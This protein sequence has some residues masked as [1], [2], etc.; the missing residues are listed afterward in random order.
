MSYLDDSLLRA[1]FWG[2]ILISMA[3]AWMGTVL[4]LQRRT[5]VGELVSHAS[6]P[7][8]VLMILITSGVAPEWAIWLGGVATSWFV[9]RALHAMER[10]NTK[11]DAA[12]TFL[13]ASS[14]GVGIL[15]VSYLQGTLPR[16]TLL[17][18]SF[19]YGQAATLTDSAV[20]LY[21]VLA[22]LIGLFWLAAF[23]LLRTHL[24]DRAFAQSR[25]V[26]VARLDQILLLLTLC[27]IALGIRSVGVILMTGL[28]IAPPIAAR[29]WTNRLGMLWVIAGAI[30]ALSGMVGLVISVEGALAWK[31]Y[32][33]LSRFTLPT[34]PVIVLVGA[35]CALFSLLFAP[36]RGWIARSLR[37]RSF[38]RQ[39]QEEHLLKALWKKEEV[40]S[41][42]ALQRLVRQGWVS[43][44]GR[45][46]EDGERRAASIVRLH[47]LWEVYL[48]EL[49]VDPHQVHTSAEEMEHV[50]TREMEERL[51]KLLS[52]PKADP[53]DQPIPERGAKR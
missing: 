10:R 49:G 31:A 47:R 30:G 34:G 26:P 12:L 17:L 32:T 19:L 44:E 18:Q 11:T 50:L 39:V 15:A 38:R 46:T 2:S 37:L 40:K 9:L 14:F 33:G 20:R 21:A 27:T 1:P 5:L 13:V 29:A 16:A 28:L 51:T 25:G 42:R 4:Y 35:F 22:L 23:P 48:T 8:I 3:A 52:D 24:F 45:L 41:S 53:H 6:Y 7:G 36:E 43:R